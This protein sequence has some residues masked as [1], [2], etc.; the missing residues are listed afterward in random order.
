M[1][2]QVDGR[3]TFLRVPEDAGGIAERATRKRGK[4]CES[5]TKPIQGARF[6]LP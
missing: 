5:Y 2:K 4:L 6:S 3:V 1:Q